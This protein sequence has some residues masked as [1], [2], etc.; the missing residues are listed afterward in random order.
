MSSRGSAACS[1]RSAESSRVSEVGGV[2]GKARRGKYCE[3]VG[4]DGPTTLYAFREESPFSTATSRKVMWREEE[5]S[6][7]RAS[8][9]A[10]TPAAGEIVI[11]WLG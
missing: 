5:K 2:R 6:E 4:A 7:E 9:S 1:L 11:S 8:S 3:K 10:E